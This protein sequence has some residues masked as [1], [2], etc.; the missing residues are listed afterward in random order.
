[1]VKVG[2]WFYVL[3]HG[4][5]PPDHQIRRIAELD[6]IRAELSEKLADL[7]PQLV[8]DVIFTSNRRVALTEPEEQTI[9][10]GLDL[11][12]PQVA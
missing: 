3:I 12:R 7:H 6:E 4:I 10:A 11:M 1:M 8:V 5:F 9:G 2:R